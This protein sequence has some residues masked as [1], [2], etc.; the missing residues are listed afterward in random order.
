MV[1]PNCDGSEKNVGLRT[2]EEKPQNSGRVGLRAYLE[3]NLLHNGRQWE[4]LMAQNRD[5][6]WKF[7]ARWYSSTPGDDA[8]WRMIQRYC[9]YRNTFHYSY[10]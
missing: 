8:T 6:N 9:Y 2:L 7:K 10:Y 5:G 3:L 1:A 4:H